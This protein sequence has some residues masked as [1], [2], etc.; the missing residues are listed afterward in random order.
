MTQ[1]RKR[2]FFYPP[3]EATFDTKS[4]LSWYHQD[5]VPGEAIE[6]IQEPGDVLFVP[7]H[8]AHATINLQTSFGIALELLL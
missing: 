3:S 6:C 2:W 7:D 5:Y 4:A 1:G 8:W